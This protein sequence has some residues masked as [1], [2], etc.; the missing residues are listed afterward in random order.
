MGWWDFRSAAE[1]MVNTRAADDGRG[2]EGRQP[3]KHKRR[4]TRVLDMSINHS[5]SLF[6]VGA[7]PNRY[8]RHS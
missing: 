3:Q 7:H 6:F 8:G 2:K 5:P 4:T 1:P